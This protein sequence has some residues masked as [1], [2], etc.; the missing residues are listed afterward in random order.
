MRHERPSKKDLEKLYQA[1]GKEALVWYAWRNSMRDL[2]LLWRVKLRDSWKNDTIKHVFSACRVLIVLGSQPGGG[3]LSAAADATADATAT[4]AD[5]TTGA[6]AAFVDGYFD[7]SIYFTHTSIYF[8]HTVAFA[9]AAAAAADYNFLM[10]STSAV[11]EY[12]FSQPLWRKNEVGQSLKPHNIDRYF[13]QLL[14]NL[15]ELDLGFLADDLNLL[16][17][18]AGNPTQPHWGQYSENP[19]D[20]AFVS[21]A[22]LHDFIFEASAEVKAVRILLLGPGG[23]GKTTLADRLQGIDT[24]A[25]H[26]AT[27]GIDYLSYEPLDLN[28]DEGAFADL[29]SDDLQL[30]L[31]DFGGQTLFH[32]LHQAFLHENCVYVLVVDSRHE[33]APDEWLQQIRHIAQSSS[34]PPVLLVVNNYDNCHS[35]QNESR[36]RQL[37]GGPLSFHYFQCNKPDD[38]GLKTFKIKLLTEAK[39][40]RHYITKSV[41]AAGDTL[42]ANLQQNPV[43]QRDALWAELKNTFSEDKVNDVLKQLE[44][45]GY[46]VPVADGKDDY[47]LNPTWTIDHAYQFLNLPCVSDKQGLIDKDAFSNAAFALCQEIKEIKGSDYPGVD[48]DGRRFLHQFLKSSG[49]CIEMAGSKKLFFPN[50]AS[51]IEPAD[52]IKSQAVSRPVYEFQLPHFPFGLTARLVNRWMQASKIQI[53]GSDDVWR[54]GFVLRY[55][56]SVAGKEND[57]L[58]VRYQFRKAMISVD[59][60]GDHEAV[61]PL[62]TEFWQG[63]KT[64]IK[65]IQKEDVIVLPRFDKLILDKRHHLS[66]LTQWLGDEGRVVKALD[67]IRQQAKDIQELKQRGDGVVNNINNS[68]TITGPVVVGGSGNT[69]TQGD[70]TFTIEREDHKEILLQAIQKVYEDHRGQMKLEHRERLVTVEKQITEGNLEQSWHKKLQ[71]LLASG[72]NVAS[73]ATALAPLCGLF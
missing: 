65:P 44:S 38:V 25:P 17:Q 47:C 33:Q 36:L 49:V 46:I 51:A 58:I 41:L 32:G 7:T 50:M 18:G 59:C 29:D 72:A 56:K 2:P 60:I 21:A 45:L 12:W 55:A 24:V 53:T 54:E 15:S 34:L 57:Y 63:L 23:A 16:Y 42:R 48:D 6:A 67:T 26:K 22:S 69:Q 61:A 4:A 11:E 13:K 31:W 73:I 30:F 1:K 10:K 62:L 43:I 66:Q 68:G 71:P 8:T 37:Y 20:A 3:K 64:L 19:S 52:Y 28:P 14:Q 70:V 9:A 5:S 40:A 35:P 27:V 39:G